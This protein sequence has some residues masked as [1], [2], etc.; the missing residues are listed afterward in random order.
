MTAPPGVLA[1]DIDD[2]GDVDLDDFS[3][4]RQ[5]FGFGVPAPPASAPPAAGAAIPEPATL[6]LLAFGGLAALRRR[7][8]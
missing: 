7:R 5:G 8:K 1:G 6:C 2:D 4:L 3:L